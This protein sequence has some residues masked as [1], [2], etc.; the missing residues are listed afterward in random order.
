MK[1]QTFDIKALHNKPGG[2]MRGA[3]ATRHA[4]PLS[5][6]G[7]GDCGGTCGGC[8]GKSHGGEAETAAAIN[9]AELLG[10]AMVCFQAVAALSGLGIFLIQARAYGDRKRS[11]KSR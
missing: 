8:S 1:I 4:K 7:C 11:R 9:I 5:G 2:P 6:L 10:T 3:I